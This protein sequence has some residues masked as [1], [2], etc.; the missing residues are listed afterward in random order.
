MSKK[1][2]LLLSAYDARSHRYWHQSMVAQFPQYDWHV[3]TLKDRFFAWRMGGNAL[4]FK[5]QFDAYLCRGDYDRVIATSM[6][7]LS[8]LR[9]LYPKL[10]E[11]PNTLYFHE[12]QFAYPENN[13]QQGLLEIQIRNIYAAIAADHLT[14]NTNYNRTTFLQG[15]EAFC[16]KMPDGLP[17]NLVEQLAQKSSLLAVPIADDCCST[18]P[19]KIKETGRLQVVWNHRWEHDKG[20]ETLL[21]LLRLCQTTTTN[22][23]EI[24]FHILGQKFRQIPQAME[25][26]TQHH[27][28]QCQTL[29]FIESRAAYIQVLQSAD[30]VLSTAHHDFQGIAMLEAVA[31][32]CLPIA[33]NRL[34]YPELYPKSN[35]YPS[36]PN[37]AQQEAKAIFSLLLNHLQLQPPELNLHWG[38]MKTEYDHWL[39]E[40]FQPH[41]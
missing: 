36:T 26:I 24:T 12:N 10:T 3:L 29:G 27:A 32:G 15:V 20:P 25:M 4:S 31:C 40:P 17:K 38:Q 41:D 34:V 14:F 11:I 33:P 23:A 37:Q 22:M 28:S 16:K 8:T 13:K 30:V 1:R 5:A 21:E 9:G 19:S 7:D 6:T 35:L 39:L 2:I 18:R